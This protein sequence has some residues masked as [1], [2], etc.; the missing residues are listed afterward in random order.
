MQQ[1]ESLLFGFI[2]VE[3]KGLSV[4]RVRASP[5]RWFFKFRCAVGVNTNLFT[6]M[7]F[8]ESLFRSC[9]TRKDGL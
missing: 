8:I 5:M 1:R 6:P 7:E 3:S 2:F 9:F 4:S